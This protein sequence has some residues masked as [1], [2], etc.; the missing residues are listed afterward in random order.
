MNKSQN[1]ILADENV[2]LQS[3]IISTLLYFDIFSYPLNRQELKN[4]CPFP[5]ESDT[6]FNEALSNLT[7][8]KFIK[9]SKGFYLVNND[10]TIIDRRIKGNFLAEDY[11]TLAK[12]YSGII[13][14]FPFVKAV[15]ISGSLSKG[16]MDKD[17]DIDFFI[18][19]EKGKLWLCRMLLVI[20]KKIFLLNSHKYFCINYFIDESSL[21]IPDKNI[22]SAT[23]LR[24]LLPM[25]NESLYRRFLEKNSWAAEFLPNN[26]LQKSFRIK[27]YKNAMV[28]R[29]FETILSL[30][31][32]R[33]L[34]DYCF[35]M[36]LNYWKKK[37][38]HFSE[39][40]FKH[41][42]RSR[43]NVSKH[44]PNKFQEKVLKLHKE[45]LALFE[46]KYEMSFEYSNGLSKSFFQ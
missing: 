26:S 38:N 37:F 25:Y 20:F 33:K 46:K 35:K 10:F 44:H 4:F 17:S 5:V 22:Y 15:F 9:Y 18:I 41:A 40:D 43:K 36:T 34:D 1:F 13:S 31:I 11:H 24:T 23:E 3:G 7:G 39:E 2:D 29:F 45:K 12:K 19:T 30:N 27:P 42:L 6:V 14:K 32:F 8:R 16:Y 28:K 21:E